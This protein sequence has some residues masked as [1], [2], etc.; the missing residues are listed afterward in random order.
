MLA[1]DEALKRLEQRDPRAAEVVKLRYFAGLPLPDVA[2]AL[3]VSLATAE[4]DWAYAKSWL[5]SQL[6]APG[7]TH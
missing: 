3:S 6:S 4:N 5:R 1:L 2:A 7:D